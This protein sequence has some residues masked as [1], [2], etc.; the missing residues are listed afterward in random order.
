M[1]SRLPA[2][3][4]LPVA[5]RVTATAQV[6]QRAIFAGAFL[7]KRRTRDSQGFEWQIRG[8]AHRKTKV[9]VGHRTGPRSFTGPCR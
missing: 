4:A 3:L 7:T 5:G 6:Q 1:L 2:M 8:D 9:E